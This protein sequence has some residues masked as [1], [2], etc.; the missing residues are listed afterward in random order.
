MSEKAILPEIF[1][2]TLAFS[3]GQTDDVVRQLARHAGINTPMKY[4]HQTGDP[5]NKAVAQL[6]I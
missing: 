4:I 1:Q 2:Q 5:L 3:G 6:D